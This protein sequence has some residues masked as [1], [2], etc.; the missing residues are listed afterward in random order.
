MRELMEK[1]MFGLEKFSNLI[2]NCRSPSVR[3]ELLRLIRTKL[4][5][6]YAAYFNFPS[7]LLSENADQLATETINSLCF[8]RGLVINFFKSKKNKNKSLILCNKLKVNKGVARGT[9]SKRQNFG[10]HLI[11]TSQKSTP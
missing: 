6:N 3:I 4:L 1:K 9:L 8:G 2:S 10:V 7:V 5:A 11:L